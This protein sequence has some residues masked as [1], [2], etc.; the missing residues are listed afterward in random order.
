MMARKSRS[1]SSQRGRSQRS[2]ASSSGGAYWGRL[3][4][5][6]LTGILLLVVAFFGASQL[7][8][9]EF[10]TLQ[11]DRTPR[12][13][14]ALTWELS[15]DELHSSLRP[16][17]AGGEERSSDNTEEVPAA[18]GPVRVYVTNGC[19]ANLLAAGYRPLFQEAGFDVCGVSNADRSD[20]VETLV[21]DR[22]G[23]PGAAASVCAYLREIHGIGKLLLQ[24]RAVSPEGDV[25]V[26]LG[27]DA[28]PAL[29][30]EEQDQGGRSTDG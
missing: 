2:R 30:S 13:T 1:R 25:L 29:D 24:T 21:V 7:G 17:R 16:S 4:R 11:P 23:Q 18:N 28:A 22:S 3:A 9:I 10:R 27:Q 5:G 14:P 20:Y 12:I 8:L 15:P 26:I 19:G 6:L